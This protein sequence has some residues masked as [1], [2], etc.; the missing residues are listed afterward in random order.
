MATHRTTGLTSG[1]FQQGG[2]WL[3]SR[4]GNPARDIKPL[5]VFKKAKPKATVEQAM[6]AGD[7]TASQRIAGGGNRASDSGTVRRWCRVKR[8]QNCAHC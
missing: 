3:S 7:K 2:S 8:P 5:P 1:R 4:E 6:S